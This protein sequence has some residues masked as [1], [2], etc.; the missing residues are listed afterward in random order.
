M[1]VFKT[2][3]CS[4]AQR[5]ADTAAAR[6]KLLEAGAELGPEFESIGLPLVS[7]SDSTGGDTYDRGAFRGRFVLNCRLYSGDYQHTPGGPVRFTI[8]RWGAEPEQAGCVRVGKGSHLNSTSITSYVGI[9]IGDN[10]H[11][12][13]RVLIMDSPGHP[14][15]R[16]L[17]DVIAN[18]RMAPVVIGDN[19][20]IGYNAVILPGV[21]VGRNAVVKPGAV[22]MWNVPENGVVGGN[23][24]KSLK[25][26]KKYFD[27]QPQ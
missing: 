23:P 2:M 8:I 18:K 9:T 6:E 4:D 20:W 22:V 13:P 5:A 21:T 24:A 12:E 25:V 15:D 7:M 3:E 10:V 16:R 1:A 27:G 19:A 14:I 26:F 11:L 17:E